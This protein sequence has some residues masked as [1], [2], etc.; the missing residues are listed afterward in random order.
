MSAQ[1]A[2]AGGVFDVSIGDDDIAELRQLVDDIGRRSF[3]ARLGHRG[4]PE[5][6]DQALWANL[7]DSGLTRLT[8]TPDLG[9]GP[10]S[11]R[12]CCAGWPPRRCRAARRNGFA[13]G[14]AGAAGRPHAAP[15]P[16]T[17][18][19]A[20][21]KPAE[22]GSPEPRTMCRGP[23]HRPRWCSPPVAPPAFTSR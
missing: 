14:L 10:P 3:D 6:F 22:A 15:G 20:D 21:A 16:L 11:W 17:V 23:G 2:L 4:L 5:Q 7:E 1:K 9:A 13:C 19:I 18:A 12:P 8:S